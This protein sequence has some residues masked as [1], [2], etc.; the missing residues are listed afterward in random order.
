MRNCKIWILM[1]ILMCAV[2]CAAGAEY[3]NYCGGLHSHTSYSDGKGVPEEAYDYARNTA[4]VDFWAITDHFEFLTLP[5]EVAQG[6][7]SE[8]D[9]L[10]KAADA[11]N[12]DGEFVAIAGFE[13]SMDVLTGHINVMN[14]KETPVHGKVGFLSPF[15]RWLARTPAETIAGFNHPGDEERMFNDFKYDPKID[16]RIIYIEVFNDQGKAKFYRD[17]YFKAL[18]AGWHVAP[19]GAQDNH[20]PDWG[21]R[22]G[23][24]TCVWAEELTREAV[25]SALR[26]LRFY[27]AND[28][29]LSLSF[30][31]N[32]VWMGQKVKGKTAE[33]IVEA[34]DTDNDVIKL[35]RILTEGGNVVEE[36]QVNAPDAYL[37]ITVPINAKTYLVAE[38]IEEDGNSAFSAPIWYEP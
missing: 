14:T 23:N 4:G 21:T 28:A 36:R 17:K 34:H 27:A 31:G 15:Y 7:V 24:K 1:L 16:E 5:A 30:H 9:K 20:R 10:L 8:W 35:V 12:D 38:V 19:A 11:K 32:D 37:N 2:K 22:S 13:W 3:H 6:E 26:S 18:D 29:N 25:F 33:L